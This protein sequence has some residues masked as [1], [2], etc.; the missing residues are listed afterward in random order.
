MLVWT[1]FLRGNSSSQDITDII[2]KKML[3]LSLGNA[4]FRSALHGQ[5][6][7]LLQAGKKLKEGSKN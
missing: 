5:P 3:L 4:V 6:H 2:L 1:A 7:S